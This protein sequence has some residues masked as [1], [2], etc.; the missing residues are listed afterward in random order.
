MLPAHAADKGYSTA[1]F[2]A[3]WSQHNVSGA[4]WRRGIGSWL[5]TQQPGKNGVLRS[6]A[7]GNC[8]DCRRDP[9]AAHARSGGVA[10]TLELVDGNRQ[11]LRHLSRRF[12]REREIFVHDL[13]ASN[14]S[15]EVRARRIPTGDERGSLWSSE[16]DSGCTESCTELVRTTTL[17]DFFAAQRLRGAYRVLIDTEGSDALVLEGMAQVREAKRSF[18]LP[19]DPSEKE[20]NPP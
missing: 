10:H 4:Q 12:G 20:E 18:F 3:Q 6:G 17:D 13:A 15:R 5:D 11:L 19:R 2:M 7:C 9:P 16:A 14:V 1:E 8:H